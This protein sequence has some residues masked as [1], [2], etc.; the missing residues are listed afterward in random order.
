MNVFASD[1]ANVTAGLGITTGNIE[2]WP[3]NYGTGNAVAVPGA[4]GR[5]GTLESHRLNPILFLREGCAL[6]GSLPVRNRQE[7]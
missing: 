1:N 3:N 4:G 5:P 2:F 6:P 7:V